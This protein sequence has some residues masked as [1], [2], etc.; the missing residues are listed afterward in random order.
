MVVR[1]SIKFLLVAGSFYIITYRPLKNT[2][3]ESK[4]K[5]WR[6]AKHYVSNEKFCIYSSEEVVEPKTVPTINVTESFLN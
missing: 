4:F 1:S 3:S 2:I 5:L 6:K